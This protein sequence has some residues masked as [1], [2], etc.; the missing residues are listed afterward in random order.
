[1]R[2]ERNWCV[3]L[4]FHR[5]R[6]QPFPQQVAH[7]ASLD[8]LP[9]GVHD[10]E[11][12]AKALSAE[13]DPVRDVDFSRKRLCCDPQITD[14]E[15]FAREQQPS[16][17]SGKKFLGARFVQQ[18][19]R[20][21]PGFDVLHV[22]G[23][24]QVLELVEVE[25]AGDGI[26]S[27]QALL[28]FVVQDSDAKELE[29]NVEVSHRMQRPINHVAH[30]GAGRPGS[31]FLSCLLTVRIRNQGADSRHTALSEIILQSDN[32]QQKRHAGFL[33]HALL[34]QRN[35]LLRI[36]FILAELCGRHSK[37]AAEVWGSRLL[38]Q[39]E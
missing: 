16:H 21:V 8:A 18:H 23:F 25:F 29:G 17:L 28:L 34:W 4:A 19:L 32:Y 3:A 11:A 26:Y 35:F 31:E 6:G 1:M 22:V 12:S 33:A 13:P 5:H 20:T 30:G 36:Q 38:M 39:P 9:H 15:K 14:M 37:T 24:R 2:V 10:V 27:K 7:F